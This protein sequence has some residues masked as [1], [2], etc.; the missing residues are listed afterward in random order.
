MTKPPRIKGPGRPTR[1]PRLIAI[2]S[3]R[4]RLKR[5]RCQIS[6]APPRCRLKRRR[7]QISDIRMSNSSYSRCASQV[8]M[9]APAKK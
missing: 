2:A 8:Y 5:C 9:P 1:T 6:V 4:L 7:H 3:P